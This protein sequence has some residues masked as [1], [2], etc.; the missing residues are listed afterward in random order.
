[1]PKAMP[2]L[3]PLAPSSFPEL[4]AI[5]GVKLNAVNCGIRYKERPDL[6]LVELVAGT[7]VAGVMTTTSMPAAP[8]QWCKEALIA[9]K[10][11]ALVVNAGNANAFTGAIG[12]QSVQNIVSATSQLLGCAEKEV[13]IASTGVIGQPLKDEKITAALPALHHS[14]ASDNW[15]SAARSI[16][17]T[18]TFKKIATRTATID[19]VAVTINGFVKGSGMIA[20]NM[21]TMLGFVFTDAA[22]PASVL[23]EIFSIACDRS[24]NSITVDSDTS[25][26]DAALLFATGQTSHKAVTSAQDAHLQDFIAKLQDLLIE[27][28]QLIVKDGEGASKFVTVTVAGAE[29][30]A[31][32]RRMALAIGNSPLVKTAIAG[33]DANWGRLVMA[34]GKSG[35]KAIQEKLRITIG[36]VLVALNGAVNPYYVEAPTAAYMKGSDIDITVDVGVGEAQATIWTCDLTHGYI[37]I[38]ADYRS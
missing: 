21:A 5:A 32:A 8:V 25:T 23:Q 2:T 19:G 26:N 1:M 36:G 7:T 28:A 11:R 37:E 27:L 29:S 3:S 15:D 13:F 6:L 18:D 17:T 35:E 14:I 10:A 33:E 20:P 9:G 34:V 31:A 22:I 24:F 16:L 12:M 4:P 38:N 30:E